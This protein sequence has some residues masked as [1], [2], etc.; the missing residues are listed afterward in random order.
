MRTR[1]GRVAGGWDPASLRDPSHRTRRRPRHDHHHLRPKRAG[2][3][4]CRLS[5]GRQGSLFQKACQIGARYAANSRPDLSD[6]LT[7][8]T[9]PSCYTVGCGHRARDFDVL[10]LWAIDGPIRLRL[11]PMEERVQPPSHDDQDPCRSY[12][13]SHVR[14]YAAASMPDSPTTP[15]STKTD[16]RRRE[17]PCR[18]RLRGSRRRGT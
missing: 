18:R 10:G 16:L 15:R 13:V 2:T 3:G 6:I 11:L 1:R 9:I 8:V 5:L 7:V 14:A 4:R 12:F 17:V